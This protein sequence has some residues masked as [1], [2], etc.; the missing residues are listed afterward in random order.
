MI[1]FPAIEAFFAAWKDAWCFFEEPRR[2]PLAFNEKCDNSRQCPVLEDVFINGVVTHCTRLDFIGD[3]GKLRSYRTAIEEAIGKLAALAVDIDLPEGCDSLFLLDHLFKALADQQGEQWERRGRPLVDFD[4]G[5]QLGRRL[6]GSDSTR[7]MIRDVEGELERHRPDLDVIFEHID[8]SKMR[9]YV[10]ALMYIATW[11]D[12]GQFCPMVAVMVDRIIEHCSFAPELPPGELATLRRCLK[13]A[14]NRRLKDTVAKGKQQGGGWLSRFGCGVVSAA[15]GI[16]AVGLI[17]GAGAVASV[18]ALP[19]ALIMG[20]V[21]VAFTYGAYQFGHYAVKGK[22]D[23]RMHLDELNRVPPSRSRDAPHGPVAYGP[24]P[25]GPVAYGPPPHGPAIATV[26]SE[27]PATVVSERPATATAA[28]SRRATT[29]A[30][31]PRRATTAAAPPRPAIATAAPPRPAIATVAPSPA[32]RR[33]ER[34]TP[35]RKTNI[36]A[37]A[38]L[39]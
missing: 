34:S 18:G 22:F 27:R 9:G 32:H 28:P 1:D 4:K 35:P 8:V 19:I 17:G 7:D 24:P 5:L 21:G 23:R 15:C 39:V 10:G 38:S 36:R 6:T 31:P 29:A 33:A 20:A 26:V 11:E 12:G 13:D 37:R 16:V 25:H 30:A 3:P 14:V 2:H